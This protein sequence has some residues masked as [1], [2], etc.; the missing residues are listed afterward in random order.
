MVISLLTLQIK[1]RAPK[2]GTDTTRPSSADG[3]ANVADTENDFSCSSAKKLR[4]SSD[5]DKNECDTYYILMSFP[6]LQAAI[7]RCR[8][9]FCQESLNLVDN[10]P[11]RAG[12]SLK[13]SFQ[14]RKCGI[15]ETF[16]SSPA[17]YN[18]YPDSKR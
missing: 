2:L 11:F 7:T 17:T 14:C 6:I 4:L 12:S 13:L 10:D 8:C 16:Y 15:L 18:V 1:D 3:T 5:S 9:E